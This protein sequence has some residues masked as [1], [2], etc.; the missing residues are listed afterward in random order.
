MKKHS[1]AIEDLP[2]NNAQDRILQDLKTIKEDMSDSISEDDSDRNVEKF[3]DFIGGKSSSFV[4]KILKYSI[5]TAIVFILF[6]VFSN[7]YLN[8]QFFDLEILM[9]YSGT[10]IGN[11][12]VGLVVAILYFLIRFFKDY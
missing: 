8:R 4:N 6:V 2:D 7:K 1:T 11:S 3:Q 12:I 5:D 10:I 9:P